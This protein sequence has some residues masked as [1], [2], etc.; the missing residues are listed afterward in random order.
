MK[1]KIQNEKLRMKK[2]G[3]QRASGGT[4]N[5]Q[6][7][8]LNVQLC[9]PCKRL[10]INGGQASSG[11]VR[12]FNFKIFF[13]RRSMSDNHERRWTQIGAEDGQ[14]GMGQAHLFRILNLSDRIRL[15]PSV[16]FLFVPYGPPRT[17]RVGGAGIKGMAALQ[18]ARCA[19]KIC[20]IRLRQ[21]FGATGC[22]KLHQPR[23]WK[24]QRL[25]AIN[26]D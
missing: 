21:G 20:R 8:T 4:F 24:K 10:G 12:P 11:F 2:P 16:Q 19:V 5:T 14:P 23:V 7:L 25:T 1:L 3:A 22:D 15:N 13:N 18:S 9:A 6:H 26:S 17:G